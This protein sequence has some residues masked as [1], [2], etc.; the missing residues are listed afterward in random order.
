MSAPV[1]V[2]VDVRAVAPPGGA[3]AVVD[4]FLPPAD[5]GPAGTLWW[6]LPGGGMSRRYWDLDLP[7]AGLARFLAARGHVAVT[8]DHLGVGE[9]SVPD[10]PY[11]LTAHAVADVNAAVLRSVADGLRAGTIGPEPLPGLRT[12]G[13][14]HSAGA[15]LLVTQQARHGGCEALALLGY[16]GRGMPEQL[17]PALARYADDP[18]GLRRALPGL[19]RDRFGTALPDLDRRHGRDRSAEPGVPGALAR[20][21]TPLL[22]L[23]GLAAMVP[24]NAA[25]EIAALDVPVLL[26]H[27]DREIGAPLAEVAPEFCGTGD[28]TLYR[29]T[30]SGHHH[31]VGPHRGRL[32]DRLLAWAGA[33]L[34]RGER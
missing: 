18:D 25:A 17:D 34:P 21:S 7:G 4:V 29:V 8:V 16:G 27:G 5:V 23:V 20:A 30:D 28:L 9:S 1:T 10:D 33:V 14:G 22:A 3:R 31:V 24:G 6:L 15:G 11:A 26:A 12:V 2:E 19:V 32:F 13:V